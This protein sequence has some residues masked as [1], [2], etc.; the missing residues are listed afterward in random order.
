MMK[1]GRT[2][3]DLNCDVGEGSTPE[4][5]D[6]ERQVMEQVTSANIACGAH[7]GSPELMRG[8]VRAAAR[9]GLAVGA[10]PGFPDREGLGR[11]EQAWSPDAIENL[12]AYQVGA[13]R[14][15]ATLEGAKLTHVK[16][17]GALYNMAGNDYNLALAVAKAVA[18]VDRTLILVGLAGSRLIEAGREMGLRVA[19]EAFVDRAY[20]GDGRLVRRDR[21]GAL[22]ADEKAVVRRVHDLIEHSRIWS[23]EGVALSMDPDTICLHADTPGAPALARA[24]RAALAA[25]GVSPRR[26][27]HPDA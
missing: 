16:P 1:H 26:L 2:H 8:T 22:L 21:P 12:I 4:Q 23:V 18:A 27:D 25:A 11:Q 10:H 19:A 24:I 9:L 20:H 17:H 7:A 14:A 13:L 5:L 15:I 3:I 6:V